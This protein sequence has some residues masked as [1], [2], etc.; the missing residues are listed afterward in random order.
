MADSRSPTIALPDD[1]RQS[2]TARGIQRGVCGLLTQRDFAALPEFSL[3]TGRRA[4]I[5]A[6]GPG[7]AVWI[8][9]IKSSVQ[10]FRSDGKWPDYRDYCDAFFF[11]VPP[12]LP[13]EILPD[14][15]GL[16]VAD[17]YGAEILRP[18]P[19]HKLV[20]GRRKSVILRFARAASGRLMGV[21]RVLSDFA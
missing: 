14:D 15:T 18:A 8:V 12:D 17:A 16:I 11:A 20:A 4:D 1:G 13:L 9:E 21:D 3:A 2:P 7:G 5:I 10:D 19:E 6:V